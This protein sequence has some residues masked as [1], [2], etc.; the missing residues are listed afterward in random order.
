[1]RSSVMGGSRCAIDVSPD[2]T[3][4]VLCGADSELQIVNVSDGK[5][6]VVASILR[7]LE[8]RLHH[9]AVVTP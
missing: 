7:H 9:D 4:A 3:H 1:M 5:E 2:G 6:V 8:G